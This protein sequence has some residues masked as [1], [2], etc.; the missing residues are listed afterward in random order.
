MIIING[1]NDIAEIKEG[2]NTY[3]AVGN[4]VSDNSGIP[5]TLPPDPDSRIISIDFAGSGDE[6]LT[7]P[8]TP[9]PV[10]GGEYNSY[11]KIPLELIVKSGNITE[12]GDGGILIQKA[13]TYTT[14]NAWLI[15][16]S[17]ANANNVGF[18]FGLERDG[19][20]YFTQ[21]VTGGRM[22]NANDLTNVSGGGISQDLKVGDKLY[23]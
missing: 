3:I 21:R 17:S 16:S 5:S 19:L 22:A 9:Q 4:T 2:L 1:N 11:L 6:L 20:I 14:P 8:P 10:T 15:M 23:L 18:I 7:P 13:G 12:T